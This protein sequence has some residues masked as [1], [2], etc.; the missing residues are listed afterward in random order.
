MLPYNPLYNPL[1][2]S[3]TYPVIL[4]ENLKRFAT[5]CP[6]THFKNLC[7]IKFGLIVFL[8]TAG[9]AI[10]ALVKKIAGACIPSEIFKSVVVA[11]AIIVTCLKAV[12]TWANKRIK[13]CMVNTDHN[14]IIPA[15]K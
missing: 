1:H 11:N 7:G 13:D 6:L 3:V 5:G 15:M 2:V 14:H 8:S 4:C 9:C 12:W 10:L